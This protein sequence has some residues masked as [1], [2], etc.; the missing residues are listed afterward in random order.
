MSEIYALSDDVLTPDETIVAQVDEILRFGVKYF[1]FRS[2]KA[3][4]NQA[5]AREILSLCQ[6]YNAKFIVNDDIYFA[7]SI[8]ANAVHLGKD[9][10]DINKAREILG[11]DTFIGVSCY[12]DVNLAIKAQ[13]DGASYV[14]FGSVFS[15]QTKPNAPRVSLETLKKAKEILNIPICAIGGI[16]ASN[17]DQIYDL[18]IDLIAVVTAIYR[19]NSITKNLKALSHNRI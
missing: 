1:Q 12:N 19:P 16:N 15:S 10:A 8:G 11:K 18:D 9:D 13:E 7:K 17:I 6:K 14:A 5:V 2:K 4:K 3:V